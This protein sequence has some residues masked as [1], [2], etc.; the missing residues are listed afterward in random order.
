M[1]QV[2]RQ[3]PP[4]LVTELRAANNFVMLDRHAAARLDRRTYMRTWGEKAR[5]PGF[6]PAAPN[7]A[8][9]D[10]ATSSSA[11]GGAIQEPAPRLIQVSVQQIL[12]LRS[13]SLPG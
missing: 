7:P 13:A 9:P 12:N 5:Q 1:S 6:P 3:A 4:I 11:A 2:H 8:A 10:G